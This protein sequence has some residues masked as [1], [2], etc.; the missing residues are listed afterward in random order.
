[1]VSATSEQD[2]RGLAAAVTGASS[3]IGEA[4]CQRL[5]HM[6]V[7]VLLI[8]RSESGLKRVQS[9]IQAR[10][11]VAAILAVDV[12]DPSAGAAIRAQAEAA[13][14]GVDIL[15]NNAGVNHRGAFEDRS[16][17]QIRQIIDVNLTAPLLLCDA[18]IPSMRARGGGHIINVASLAGRVPLPGE[19]TYSATKFGLRAFSFALADEVRGSGVRVSV[20]SPGP[21]QTGFILD[22]ID[23]VPDLVFSQTLCTPQQIADLVIMA[24]QKDIREATP[25]IQSRLMTNMGYLF[26]GLR[27]LMTP[28]LQ[29]RGRAVKARLRGAVPGKG[30]AVR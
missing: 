23:D 24:L 21:V 9:E 29:R 2:L 3:G 26:P 8:A 11:G 5:A 19:A 25:S 1:M 7:R 28:A 4:V 13:F 30:D 20:V 6:G 16:E 17:S 27:Q 18:L 14:G 15:V 12:S 22:E 10:G